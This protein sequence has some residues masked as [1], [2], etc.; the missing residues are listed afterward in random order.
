[1]TERDDPFLD[2]G[3]TSPDDAEELRDAR[4][5]KQKIDQV[6]AQQARAGHTHPTGHV[7]DYE[8]DRDAQL[9]AERAEYEP[10]TPEKRGIAQRGAALA[11]KALAPLLVDRIIEQVHEGTPTDPDYNDIA[12]RDEELTLNAR[13]RTHFDKQEAR[14][15]DHPHSA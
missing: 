3:Y 6:T 10:P 4:L 7:R 11:R 8:S 9:A 14:K 13:L 2:L 15:T 1:M 12:R 5:R